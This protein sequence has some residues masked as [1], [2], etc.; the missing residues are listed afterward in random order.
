MAVPQEAKDF[1]QDVRC[2]LCDCEM[3]DPQSG[4]DL[5]G[6]RCALGHGLCADCTTQYVEKTLLPRGI[7]WWD[8]IKCVLP[9]CAE[10]MHGV[11][12]R[13]CIS[14][15]LVERI[16]AAQLELVP[17]LGPEARRERERAAEVARLERASRA[18]EHR[19]SEAHVAETTVPCPAC[20]APSIK[21]DGCK[22][23]RCTCL[24]EYCWDCLCNWV[25]G[26]MSVTC[27]RP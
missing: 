17:N 20:G 15:E 9:E 25:T 1:L 10:F 2:I 11:S 18:A 23:V 3:N 5:Q 16:D 27:A 19:V 12:V 8:T 21:I 14:R 4:E 26:H 13:R 6:G 22:H 7:V 24:H